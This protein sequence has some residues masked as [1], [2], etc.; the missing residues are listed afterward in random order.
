MRDNYNLLSGYYLNETDLRDVAV[1][2]IP[3]FEPDKYNMEPAEFAGRATEFAIEAVRDGKKKLVIDLSGN[4]GGN[5]NLGMDLFKLFF[6]D[7]DIYQASRMR[8]H[9]AFNLAGQALAHLNPANHTQYI[10]CANAGGVCLA[11][12]VKPDQ[13]PDQA[14]HFD[15]WEEVY[16]PY[17][18]LGGNVSALF[19][20]EWLAKYSTPTA[21]IR[22]YGSIP[23]IPNQRL[24][25]PENIL[26]VSS[27]A[28]R[29]R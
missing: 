7:Q 23:Q 18:Q 14:S 1:L 25:E 4:P 26:L 11:A 29:I 13:T 8:S 19:G 28:I 10:E 27:P 5:L 9:E 16:G 2:A 12:F 24:F 15:S 20:V 3:S 21:P 6:P 17:E 22:G